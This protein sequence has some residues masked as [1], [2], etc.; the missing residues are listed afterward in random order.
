M[1]LFVIYEL[2]YFLS[3]FSYL[4]PPAEAVSIVDFTGVLQHIQNPELHLGIKILSL[5]CF[6]VVR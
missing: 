2:G 6:C 4:D 3:K 5:P 1:C